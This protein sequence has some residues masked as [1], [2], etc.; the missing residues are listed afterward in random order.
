MDERYVEAARGVKAE[1][2][3]EMIPRLDGSRKHQH[4]ARFL[5]E[6][7]H[8]IGLELELAREPRREGVFLVFVVRLSRDTAWFFHDDEV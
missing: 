2:I 7:M 3:F 6:A 4:A 8:D 5:V 1:L